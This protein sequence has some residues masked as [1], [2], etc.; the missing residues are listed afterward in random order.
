VAAVYPVTEVVGHEH[1]AP[2]RKGE[3]GAAFAWRALR[4]RLRRRR[5]RLPFAGDGA[6]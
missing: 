3:P 5:P 4:R 1:V 2:G 6:V